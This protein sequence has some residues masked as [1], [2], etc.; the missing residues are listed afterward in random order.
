MAGMFPRRAIVAGFL[1]GL[2]A[3]AAAP[4]PPPA[5]TV[6]LPPIAPAAAPAPA[7][8]APES[9][10]AVR[11]DGL[12]RSITKMSHR[13]L[14]FY[15]DLHVVA[16]SATPDSTPEEVAKWMTRDHG[17]SG[18]GTYAIEGTK[19][20][21][22]ETTKGYGTV[23]HRGTIQGATITIHW[24]SLINGADGDDEYHFVPARGPLP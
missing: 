23:Q 13:Y 11:F 5:V 12:Y 4:P 7:P 2:P 21:F 15:P 20:R 8:A 3:G 9:D 24:H 22:D 16:A 6:A 19:V 14:R 1:L 18:Q 17:L 10:A